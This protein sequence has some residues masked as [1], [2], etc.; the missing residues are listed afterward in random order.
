MTTNPQ[1][2]KEFEEKFPE[3]DGMWMGRAIKSGNVIIAT[4]PTPMQ[5]KQFLL[6]KLEQK[7]KEFLELIP[8]RKS[9]QKHRKDQDEWINIPRIQRAVG[10]N[11]CRQ[12]ILDNLINPLKE[13]KE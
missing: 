12:Q 10:F 6:E 8:K 4:P 7:D 13:E 1:I 11:S 5:L 3:V 2:I 9:E